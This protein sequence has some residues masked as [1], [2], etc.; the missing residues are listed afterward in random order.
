MSQLSFDKYIR[1]GAH[2][3]SEIIQ[4]ALQNAIKYNGSKVQKGEGMRIVK[5][6]I[7]GVR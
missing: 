3:Q 5:L 7:D 4:P 1:P 2:R 6:K